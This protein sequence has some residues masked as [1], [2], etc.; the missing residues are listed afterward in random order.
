MTSSL[1]QNP[2][3][4]QKVKWFDSVSDSGITLSQPAL[5]REGLLLGVQMVP[6]PA[7]NSFMIV[8]CI[9]RLPDNQIVAID[10]S[11]MKFVD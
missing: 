3:F 1:E 4:G 9:R 8:A 2:K 7:H 6:G 10:A 11:L 5:E